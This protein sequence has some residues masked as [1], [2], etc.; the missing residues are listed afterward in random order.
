MRIVL[1]G[2]PASGKGTLATALIQKLGLTH[3]ST[4]D[5]FRE[6]IRQGTE[7]GKIAKALIDKGNLV[8]DDIVVKIVDERL[9]KDDCRKGFLLDGVPRT[10]P[11]AE[12]VEKALAARG[13][14]LSFVVNLTVKDETVVKRISGRRSCPTCGAPYNT[15][16]SPP[17]KEGVCDKDGVALVSR[18][19]DNETAVRRRLEVYTTQ[20]A[21]LV[22][23]YR[24]RGLLREVS[25]EQDPK[26]VT[27]EALRAIG[28]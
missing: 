16:S 18:A 20:T 21:P 23:F 12:A 13:E 4:G 14:K 27:A 28:A 11:Q 24:T 26:S 9:A 15:F 2:A 19:D 8:P 10:I 17:K 5:I 1:L 7:L 25:G 6:A 22:D 3:V